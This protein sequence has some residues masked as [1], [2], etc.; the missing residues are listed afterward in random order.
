MGNQTKCN[1]GKWK[2]K[3]NQK[4][5]GKEKNENNKRVV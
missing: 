1:E 2:K 4:G 5:N 3:I